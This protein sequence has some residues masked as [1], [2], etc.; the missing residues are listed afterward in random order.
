M[1]DEQGRCVCVWGWCVEVEENFRLEAAGGHVAAVATEEVTDV[2]L[3]T[4]RVASR[5]VVNRQPGE[6]VGASP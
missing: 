4:D 5:A 2:L 1:C 6:M 3:L